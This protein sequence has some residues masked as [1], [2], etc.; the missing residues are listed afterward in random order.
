MSSPA[1]TAWLAGA[2]GLVGAHVLDQLLASPEFARVV[3]FT[4][5]PLQRDDAKHVNRVVDFSSLPSDAGPVDVAFC[6]LGTTMKQAGSQ[7]AFRQVDH[8]HVLSFARAAH[9]AGARRFLLVSALGADKDSTVFYNRVKGE[10]EE[11][12]RRVGFAQLTILRP[13]LLLGDRAELRLGERLFAPFSKLLPRAVRGIEASTV[14]RAMVA[15]SSR[16]GDD[17]RVVSSGEL[18]DL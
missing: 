17:A 5:R 14:A 11:A 18:F 6:C 4:R 15:L 1:H 2:T 7:Q 8:D 16:A 9:A 3:T 12:L 13:S 10:A